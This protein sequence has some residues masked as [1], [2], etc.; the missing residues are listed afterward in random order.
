[1]P[2]RRQFLK[3]T[4]AAVAATA[5]TPN[6]LSAGFDPSSWASVR[7]QFLLDD[8]VTNLTTFLLASHPKPVRDAIDRH[9]AGLDRDAKRYLDDQ[10]ETAEKRVR[11][12]AAAYLEVAADEIALTDSTTMGLGL[13]YGGLRLRPGQEVLT[14]V[15]DFYSTHESL[16]LRALR[17]GAHLRKI[18]LYGNARNVSVDE[19]VSAVRRAV[20]P[21]TRVLAVTWVHSS[22][23]VKLPVRAIANALR[24]VNARRR[25]AERILLCVDGVHGFGVE[26]ATPAELGCD[27]LVSG[28]HKWLFGPRGTG[29]VW[30][31]RNAWAA[32]TPTIPTFDSRAII[33][34]I[35]GQPSRNG[36]AGLPR[37]LAMTPG[38]FHSFEHRWAL[39]EA[40]D[41]R[42][43]IGRDRVAARTHELA[44]R[45]K[46]GLR[47]INGVRLVTPESSTLSA[48]LVCFEVANRDPMA[49]V[50]RLYDRAQ[51]I[52][53]VTPY[54][55]R[56]VR[57]GPS[58]LNS[59]GD[60]D[61]ALQAIRAL[62]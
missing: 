10:E 2:T 15:H 32:V 12:G 25:E 53:S 47:E 14:T 26:A 49:I 36:I 9:R 37:A 19:V 59:T 30:A 43:Q 46:A 13:V 1:M 7:D 23:G 22:T 60:V 35:R 27:I 41:F 18:R 34:W 51:V 24:P 50:Q 31:R 28:C 33:A 54:A 21:E 20:R 48:G 42:R 40:F 44:H 3:S 6:A 8:G 61:R 11:A 62:A 39:R 45:L 4:A 58:I 52:A 29:L 17:T 56:Y 55:T 38:G 57:L 5:Y 16:R